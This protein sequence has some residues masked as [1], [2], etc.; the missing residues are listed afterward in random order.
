M[1]QPIQVGPL[2]IT[3]IQSRHENQNL[4]NLF[5]IT[6]PAQLT[7]LPVPHLHRQYEETIIGL[8]G[9]STWIVDGQ[10]IEVGPGD[11]LVIPRGTSHTFT[12]YHDL[13]ARIM[14][15]LTPGLLGPEYFHQ[16]AAAMKLEDPY[17]TPAM[18]EVMSRYG[19]IP[20]NP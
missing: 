19:V 1:H 10:P 5:E 6:S 7:D 18:A 20:L 13:T 4:L 15:I 11:Q 16:I 3:F 2:R 8:D 17:Y 9:I 14:C 12:N